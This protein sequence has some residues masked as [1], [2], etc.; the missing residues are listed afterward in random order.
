MGILVVVDPELEVE[1]RARRSRRRFVTTM[2]LLIAAVLGVGFWLST[3]QP[4]AVA[5]EPSSSAPSLAS[6]TRDVA[7]A[8]AT[9]RLAAAAGTSLQGLAD[10][11]DDPVASPNAA[12]QAPVV[13]GAQAATQEYA[14]TLAQLTEA[15]QAAAE[16]LAMTKQDLK[17]ARKQRDEAADALAAEEEA[18]ASA[19]DAAIDAAISAAQSTTGF[20]PS[21][22]VTGTTGGGSIPQGVSTTTAEVLSYVRK[23][24][25]KSEVGNAMAVSRCESGHAN[26]VG[27][28]NANGTRDFGVF[29]LNDGGTLQAALRTIGV[30]YDDI[31]DA[32]SKALKVELN[33]R[34]AKAIWDARGWQP[35]VC[36]A[37]LKIV[38]GLYQRTHGSMYGKYDEYGRAL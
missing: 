1:S 3:Q 19:I 32:R 34:M 26:R 2:V 5:L 38:S 15:E 14:E 28:A 29:Q 22:P 25:P 21:D 31:T 4:A 33:V 36:A 17:D 30:G 10:Q 11:L 24:F 37:K 6:T 9:D 27:A 35:W 16:Q 20:L 7:A 8:M 18:A 12:E 13:A 23:Y